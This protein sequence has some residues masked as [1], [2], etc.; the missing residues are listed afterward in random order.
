MREY[1]Q[2]RL[3]EKKSNF[4]VTFKVEDIVTTGAGGPLDA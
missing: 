1:E 3:A 4:T 2:M